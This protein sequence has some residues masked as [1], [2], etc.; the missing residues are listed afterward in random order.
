ML[1]ETRGRLTDVGHWGRR[2]GGSKV[3]CNYRIWDNVDD[4]WVQGASKY[5][6]LLPASDSATISS[7][8]F[9]TAHLSSPGMGHANHSLHV[10]Q[11]T[12]QHLVP[13]DFRHV[14]KPEKG[15]IR[16]HHLDS[17]RPRMEDPLHPFCAQRGVRMEH[18]DL[19]A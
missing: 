2:L 11:A 4:R 14:P 17:Q 9:P 5:G 1:V 16:K 12:F 3:S 13:P 7:L 18:V 19:L 10:T 6:V 8:P 15:V